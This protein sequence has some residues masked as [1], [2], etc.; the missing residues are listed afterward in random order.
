MDYEIILHP[1][2]SQTGLGGEIVG[3]VKLDLDKISLPAHDLAVMPDMRGEPG[4][5]SF[6]TAK[7]TRFRIVPR[8]QVETRP[9]SQIIEEFNR[10]ALGR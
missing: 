1:G 4:D 2:Y 3:Y 5:A 8:T 6:E 10:K 9:V 7:I